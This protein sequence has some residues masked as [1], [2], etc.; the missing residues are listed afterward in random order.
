MGSIK[1]FT[2]FFLLLILM[3]TSLMA[4]NGKWFQQAPKPTGNSLFDVFVFD[5]TTVIAVGEL[6]TV[7][8]TTDDGESWY[9]QA[10]ASGT[11]VSLHSL[12]F[13]D[14]NIGWAVGDSGTVIKTTDGG[15]VWTP[16]TSG[17]TRRLY[18][19]DF[20]DANNGW[21]VG[22]SGTIL[23]STDGGASWNSQTSGTTQRLYSVDFVND[24]KGWAV[25][26]NATIL[27]T[28]NGGVNWVSLA[29]ESTASLCDVHFVNDSTGWIAGNG[30]WKENHVLKTT[31]GGT[32][33]TYP[34]SGWLFWGMYSI[35]A[36][37]ENIVYLVAIT[38]YSYPACPFS[39]QFFMTTDG[40]E[41]WSRY[42]PCH[43]YA[44]VIHFD[45]E[46]HG[47]AVGGGGL[48]YKNIGG[49]SWSKKNRSGYTF[50]IHS[51]DFLNADTG[52]AVGSYC[53]YRPH[54]TCECKSPVIRTTN[55]GEVWS[56]DGGM[57][58]ARCYSIDFINADT[59]WIVGWAE[60]MS[61]DR[62]N[63]ATDGGVIWYQR[64]NQINT[65]PR[66]VFFLDSEI[67]WIV[68][69]EGA[70]LNTTDNGINWI[71]QE[72]GTE[73][74]LQ[75]VCFVDA[76]TG[77]VVGYEGTILSTT[78]GGTEWNSQASETQAALLSV[79]FVDAF[80]G[81]AVGDSGTIINTSNGGLE[82]LQQK[83]GT[84]HCLFSVDFVDADRGWAVGYAAT[85]I[86][87]TDGGITWT[88]EP[89][90]PTRA[91]LEA[92]HFVDAN[93]GWVT[94][95]GGVIF[96]FI[97]EEETEAPE[98]P[99][100][101]EEMPG[102][103]R[104][105]QNYPNPF[106]STTTIPFTVHGK[107]KTVNSP[108]RTT[109]KVYNIRGQLVRVL[110]DQ[111]KFPGNYEVLWDGKN[112]HGNSVSSGVYFYQLKVGDITETKKLVLLK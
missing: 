97:G 108:V 3:S 41:N 5:S 71:Y 29:N 36:V 86:K 85:I 13:V 10:Y 96:K 88:H 25:G 50:P 52:W 77:W 4:Q 89:P 34:M 44:L 54:A 28:T 111:E 30:V 31:N 22:D 47:W 19:V 23:K 60:V 102:A 12:S 27:K 61:I 100:D 7:I 73:K 21:A 65:T 106:N 70:I 42:A 99:E 64:G 66:S 40:G 79:D 91:T 32:D 98:D 81:W 16:L 57:N 82:W 20:V 63:Y 6:G 94:G 37:D 90:L 95:S 53:E 78:N 1:P 18:G 51:V 24:R 101:P 68:G 92:V 59:G 55:G 56:Y 58:C 87:T 76:E 38:E 75:D 74:D 48:I 46:G 107:Q 67:G 43:T 8:K 26:N 15:E 69:D 80:T 9:I 17:T 105:G 93:T 11:S 72:S 35:H 104:L 110:V 45:K 83:S 109:L 84:E 49:N 112:K 33:W 103:F 62:I 14:S 2:G 39:T